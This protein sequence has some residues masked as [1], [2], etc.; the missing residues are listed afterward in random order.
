MSPRFSDEGGRQRDCPS[1]ADPAGS[2]RA[3][4]ERRWAEQRL[5]LELVAARL[6]AEATTLG[7]AAHRL[8]PVVCEKLAWDRGELWNVDH[9]SHTLECIE[10]WHLPSLAQDELDGVTRQISLAPEMGL[11][12]RVW[13]GGESIG[14]AEVSRDKTSPRAAALA[15]A[16]LHGGLGFAIRRERQVLGVLAFYRQARAGPTPDLLELFSVLA[17]QVAQFLRR[18]RAEQA[19]RE[20]EERFHS[21]SACS[22]VGIFQSD[23]RGHCV[24]TNPRCQA[25]GG[26]GFEEAL[27]EGWTG[28]IHPDDRERVREQWFTAAVQGGAFAAEFR[29][30]KATGAVR[31][32]AVRSAPMISARGGR[33]GLVATFEDI[34]ERKRAEAGLRRLSRR[35]I[36][37]Q[38]SERKRVARELHD[39]VIQLLA[40][41]KF[42]LLPAAGPGA[43]ARR[44]PDPPPVTDSVNLIDRAIR[45]VR[46][47]SENLRPSE[48]DELG[49]AAALRGLCAEFRERTGVPASL[50][51]R[52]PVPGLSGELELMLYRLVQEG[53]SNVEKHAAA[54]RVTVQL[55]ARDGGVELKIRDN[56]RGFEVVARQPKRGRSSGLGLLDMRERTALVNGTL[57]IR[58]AP[59]QG[60][61][62]R[63]RVPGP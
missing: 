8:L 13:S 35:I 5:D 4:V 28:F 18:R 42:R 9:R 40:S 61:E 26:F 59:G 37:A 50:R 38:E 62:I 47:I 60:T 52:P 57:T 17:Q 21:L 48:L 31:W 27:G 58:S 63:A 6:L 20:S 39:G 56:G 10:T 19:L 45:E 14:M 30:G 29:F 49:L 34:T 54:T 46:R 16:D 53:L 41:A 1:E 12:G 3:E 43:A 51:V 44:V 33:L 7:E 25:I 36:A 2:D 24:Y 23:T 55:G 22:P 15:A 32:V 11:P